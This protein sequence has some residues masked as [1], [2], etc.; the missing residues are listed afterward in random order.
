MENPTFNRREILALGTAG[1]IGITTGLVLPE[2][3]RAEAGIG[4][5]Y[6]SAHFK[7]M[8]FSFTGSDGLR[9]DRKEDN[10]YVNYRTGKQVTVKTIDEILLKEHARRRKQFLDSV[11]SDEKGEFKIKP[12]L[13]RGNLGFRDFLRFYSAAPWNCLAFEFQEKSRSFIES[14]S[15][16]SLA[17]LCEAYDSPFSYFNR[18]FTNEQQVDFLRFYRAFVKI[19][20]EQRESTGRIMFDN[21]ANEYNGRTVAADYLYSHPYMCLEMPFVPGIIE[22]F[23][24]EHRDGRNGER[25]NWRN[26]DNILDGKF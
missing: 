6:C 23:A 20:D 1:A 9:Y 16:E 10:V 22:V 5:G 26:I 11:E 3:S 15:Q 14:L 21:N 12:Q 13:K 18:Y 4:S 2:Y 25:I 7:R 17:R 8:A 19:I 24:N